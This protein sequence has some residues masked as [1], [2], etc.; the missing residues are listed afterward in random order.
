MRLTQ[1]EQVAGGL[2]IGAIGASFLFGYDRSIIIPY[3]K[4][5][6][7]PQS[8]RFYGD[9]EVEVEIAGKRTHMRLDTGNSGDVMLLKR[10]ADYLEIKN[11]FHPTKSEGFPEYHVPLTLIGED[12]NI[13]VSA[14]VMLAEDVNHRLDNDIIPAWLFTKDYAISFYPHH[15]EFIPYPVTGAVSIPRVFK[16]ERDARSPFLTIGVNG[17]PVTM[18]LDSAGSAS[19]LSHNGARHTNLHAFPKGK[20]FKTTD[21]RGP[22]VLQGYRKVPVK[23]PGL[24]PIFTE[25]Y[26]CIPDGIYEDEID[27]LTTELFTDAG[28]VVTVTDT[29]VLFDRISQELFN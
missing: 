1:E 20:I 29:H 4:V 23:V 27:A 8:I 25:L 21:S 9:P 11:K 22:L 15:A 16:K 19:M 28:Y 12:E 7:N 10:T 24:P 18:L 3:V 17:V 6:M 5:P 26:E 13:T 2:L 14:S